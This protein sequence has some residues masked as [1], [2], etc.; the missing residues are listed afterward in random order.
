MIN[1]SGTAAPHMRA[2][3]IDPDHCTVELIDVS[4]EEVSN[5]LRSELTE[6][7]DFE[8]DHCL[9]IDDGNRAQDHPT[10]FRLAKGGRPYFGPVLVMGLQHGNWASATLKPASLTT[11]IIWEEWD[12]RTERYTEAVAV[13][14]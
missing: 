12:A 13:M 10:C 8:E 2:I 1:T 4:P 7:L 3:K 6:T 5:V 9:V 14:S 11:R